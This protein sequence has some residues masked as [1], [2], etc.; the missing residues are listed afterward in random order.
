MNGRL[1]HYPSFSP[2]TL[3]AA[4][5]LGMVVSKYSS[6]FDLATEWSIL[7]TQSNRS[8]FKHSRSI[9]AV[10]ASVVACPPLSKCEIATK[11][12]RCYI[13]PQRLIMVRLIWTSHSMS[14]DTLPSFILS[15]IITTTAT[16]SFCD[17][18]TKTHVG[19]SDATEDEA[20]SSPVAHRQANRDNAAILSLR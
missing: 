3:A 10:D 14:I 15:I 6:D 13:P 7:H 16:A 17:D 18:N 11:S 5:G 19:R 20:V 8:I 9:L 1:F 4:R 2:L 12:G